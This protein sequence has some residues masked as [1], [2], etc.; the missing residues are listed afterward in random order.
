[1]GNIDPLQPRL[2]SGDNSNII[3][4]LMVLVVKTKVNGHHKWWGVN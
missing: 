2:L 4:L 1:M 3:K